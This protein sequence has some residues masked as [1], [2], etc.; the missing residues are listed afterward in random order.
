MRI[1]D[2]STRVQRAVPVDITLSAVKR[3]PPKSEAELDHWE[4][5]DE[6]EVVSLVFTAGVFAAIAERWGDLDA[7]MEA[8]SGKIELD[9]KTGQ[10]S[11][12]E[13]PKNSMGAIVHTLAIALHRNPDAVGA[14][15]SLSEIPEYT[16]ALVAAMQ[17]AQGVDP[18]MARRVA[19]RIVSAKVDPNA[20]IE[21]R[22][23]QLDSLSTPGAGTG[24]EA[25]EPS[26]DSGS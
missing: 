11:V 14:G 6:E 21:E 2:F 25:E 17:I 20:G 5:T 10:E 23:N 12:I 15:V 26:S 24:V 9:E 7:W 8:I 16:A 13:A 3:V 19:Q 1:E 18:T 22:L 4:P